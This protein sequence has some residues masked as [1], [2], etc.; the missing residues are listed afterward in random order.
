M[1]DNR[2]E[3]TIAAEMSK[4]GT[5][6]DKILL[7]RASIEFTLAITLAD[8][9]NTLLMDAESDLKKSDPYLCL[10]HEDK[11][12]FNRLRQNLQIAKVQAAKCAE[13]MYKDK[14]VSIAVDDSDFIHELLLMCVNKSGGEKKTSEMIL[15][16]INKSYKSKLPFLIKR[17]I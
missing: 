3:I 6:R 15:K 8:V 16:K 10:K 13:L 11:L 2:E 1:Q 4:A 5:I 7:H 12:N 14:A 17:E 9:I